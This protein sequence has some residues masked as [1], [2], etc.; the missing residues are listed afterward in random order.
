MSLD[1]LVFRKGDEQSRLF[2]SR[3]VVGANFS[4]SQKRISDIVVLVFK[5]LGVVTTDVVWC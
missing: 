1:V 2:V 4:F 3:K 5:V